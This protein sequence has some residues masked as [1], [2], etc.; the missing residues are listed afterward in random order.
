MV[1]E[2]DRT[3][4]QEELEQQAALVNLT[5]DAIIVRHPDGRIQFW[6]RGAER[7]YGYNASEAVGRISHELLRTRFPEALA[8]IERQLDYVG[9]WMGEIEHQRRDGRTVRVLSR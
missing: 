7:M 8:I 4:R 3:R 1:I 5:S 6:N 2:L 9:V